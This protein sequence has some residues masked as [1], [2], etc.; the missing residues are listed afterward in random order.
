MALLL[1]LVQ[2]VTEFL[3]ISSSGHLVLGQRLLGYHPSGLALEAAV[4]LATLGAIVAYY[5]GRLFRSLLVERAFWWRVGVAFGV[6]AVIGLLLRSRVEE[7]FSSLWVT[8]VGWLFTGGVLLATRWRLGKPGEGDTP[9]WWGAVLI[10]VAQGAALFPGVSRSG[11]TIAAA[12]WAGLAPREA[13]RFS[14]FLALPTILGATVFELGQEALTPQTLGVP[15]GEVLG[16][17]LAAGLSGWL[18]IRWLLRW[19]EGRRFWAFGVYCLVVGGIAL[20]LAY[21]A[22]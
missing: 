20:A 9:G 7:G 15:W 10:G 22:G 11:M 1:G 8:G 14:F 17:S 2:G 13:A 5:Q 12:L 3:P 16:A 6:T 21:R 19:L 18:A 4:H